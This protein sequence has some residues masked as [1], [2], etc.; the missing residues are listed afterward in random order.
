MEG[1][2]SWI[3]WPLTWRKKE[4]ERPLLDSTAEPLLRVCEEVFLLFIGYLRKGP[5]IPF[6]KRNHIFAI[7]KQQ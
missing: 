7:K 2:L 5:C 3:L 1:K 6:K 4:T